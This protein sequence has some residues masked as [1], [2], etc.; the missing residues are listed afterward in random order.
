MRAK[1]YRTGQWF[2]Y[3]VI[4]I[5]ISYMATLLLSVFSSNHG[6]QVELFAPE[7]AHADIVTGGGD[8]YDGGGFVGGCCGC[9]SCS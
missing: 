3:G 7:S 9:G 4:F 8:P 5:G 1:L 6:A 2:L